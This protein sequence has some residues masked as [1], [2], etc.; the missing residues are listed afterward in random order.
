MQKKVLKNL[1]VVGVFFAHPKFKKEF[2]ADNIM[3]VYFP[4]MVVDINAHS[5]LVGE[6]EYETR[7]YTEK[8]GD[9]EET[10]YDADLYH[11]ERDFD[12]TISGLTVESS[13]DKLNIHAI[14]KTNNIINS[15]MPFDIQNSVKYDAGYLR[16]F[17]SE[18]RDVNID[19]LRFLVSNQ[20][21]DIARF[22]AND[23]LKFYDRGVRW[24]SETINMKGQQWKAAYLPVWLYSYQEVKD[25]KKIL[26]YVAVNARTRET[27]GSIP[28]YKPKLIAVCVLIEIITFLIP[29]LLFLF[30]TKQ[31]FNPFLLF[32]L[33]PGIIFYLVMNY[34]YRNYNAR[35]YHE[36]ETK[37]NISNMAKVDTFIRSR[38][39]LDSAWMS[40]SNN[41]S[42]KG[43][44]SFIYR[45]QSVSNNLNKSNSDIKEQKYY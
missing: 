33:L 3:G 32:L 8:E 5:T 29:F 26:H 45:P 15:I 37:R 4:Y 27:M 42:V 20:C 17:T 31:I 10:Y 43:T 21:K 28:I 38:D 1:L 2:T 44:N 16:G 25:D 40:G 14:D 41:W 22:A 13:I 19:D 30:S 34:R 23:T 12:I 7:H 11:I 39:K 9:K 6:G 24:D 36:K 35:H 18:K